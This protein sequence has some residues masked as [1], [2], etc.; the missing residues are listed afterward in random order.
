MT[1]D[2]PQPIKEADSDRPQPID[3]VTRLRQTR[4][5]MLGTDDEAH[6]W[7]CHEAAAEIERLAAAQARAAYYARRAGYLEGALLVISWGTSGVDPQE[8][9]TRALEAV[10]EDEYERRLRVTKTLPKRKRA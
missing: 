3:I 1:N 8:A 4:A 10:G 2:R 5:N 7:D 9:A 6:Y